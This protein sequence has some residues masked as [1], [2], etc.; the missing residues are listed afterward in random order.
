MNHH[1]TSALQTI[2]GTHD[3]ALEPRPLSAVQWDADWQEAFNYADGGGLAVPS[4]GDDAAEK[5][6]WHRSLAGLERQGYVTRADKELRLTDDGHATARRLAG[7]PGGVEALDLLAAVAA[8]PAR[9]PGGWASEPSLAG[10][11]P[12]P[13][14]KVGACRIPGERLGLLLATADALVLEGLI[15]W[16]PFR[17]F[18]LYRLTEEGQRRATAGDAANW[19]K[20]VESAKTFPLSEPYVLA[21]DAAYRAREHAR[22]RWPNRVNHLD[23]VDP[24]R[25]GG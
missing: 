13:A 17:D 12:C 9:W 10:L 18:C 6:Q 11:E 4:M 2:L 1:E 5:K 21:F 25:G 24:P 22:P 15:T 23:P 7:L 3:G 20:R 19:F 8:C 16:R 14:T